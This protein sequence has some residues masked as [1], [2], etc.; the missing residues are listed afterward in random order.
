L[1]VTLGWPELDEARGLI[2][3]W[4]AENGAFAAVAGAALRIDAV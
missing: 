1:A 2:A 3:D 4:E